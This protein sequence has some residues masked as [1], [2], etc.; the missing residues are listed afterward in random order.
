MKTFSTTFV[1]SLPPASV[2][3][4]VFAG[5]VLSLAACGH[6]SQNS[7]E[8]L[9]E[10]DSAYK[11]GV[12]TKEE[13]DAKKAALGVPTTSPSTTATPQPVPV[14]SAAPA[15]PV[16]SASPAQ[17]PAAEQVAAAKT[18]DSTQ[19]E[20]EPAPLKGCEDAASRSGKDDGP[21]SRFFPEPVARVKQAAV[22][23]LR[24]MDF[25]IHRN[26]PNEIEASKKRGIGVVVGAGGERET[27]HFEAAQQGNQQGTRV[28]GETKKSG[29]GRQKPWT[30]AVLAQIACI[31]K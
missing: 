2:L 17:Q 31:L 8:Q 26:D 14:A 11:S 6:K 12:F 24:T 7:D 20:P 23:A 15:S 30:G 22:D 21:S 16:A 3:A 28:T 13:Y 9:A 25:T 10:L 18:G 1:R 29:V 19:A 27:L 5:V 4:S